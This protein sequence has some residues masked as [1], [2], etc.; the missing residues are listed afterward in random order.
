MAAQGS[1]VHVPRTESD[2]NAIISWDLA[3]EL[4][5]PALFL[6]ASLAGDSSK[7]APRFEQRELR[8][9]LAAEES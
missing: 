9:H 7:V 5:W 2:G 3:S 8:P 1:K 4:M 6:P